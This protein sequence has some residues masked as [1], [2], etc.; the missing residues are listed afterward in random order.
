MY[1]LQFQTPWYELNCEALQAVDFK[2]LMYPN[3]ALL[4][5]LINQKETSSRQAKSHA[6]DIRPQYWAKQLDLN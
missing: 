4:P 6:R 1:S 3:D 5:L 2:V